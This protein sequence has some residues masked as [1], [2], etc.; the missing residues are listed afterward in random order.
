[1]SER[2]Q[3]EWTNGHLA[4]FVGPA[5]TKNGL[6]AIYQFTV[7]VHLQ[8]GDRNLVH[9]HLLA[10]EGRVNDNAVKALAELFPTWNKALLYGDNPVDGIEDLNRIGREMGSVDGKPLPNAIPV[11]VAY[12]L[13][14][15]EGRNGKPVTIVQ[16]KT[17]GVARHGAG[18]GRA[19]A[20]PSALMAAFGKAPPPPARNRPKP[21]PPV[22]TNDADGAYAA[23]MSHGGVA[24]NFWNR[25]LEFTRVD[26]PAK[27]TADGWRGFIESVVAG[28]RPAPAP[29]PPAAPPATKSAMPATKAADDAGDDL[30][31]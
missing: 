21:P 8:D 5:T 19:A 29:A 11:R 6:G 18:A 15:F 1:M 22:F 24:D 26:D 9:E 23:F 27:I 30:P 12:V 3:W 17:I 28:A 31:F 7:T 10:Y 20:P 14:Q 25:V 16:T 2:V 13:R 4:G